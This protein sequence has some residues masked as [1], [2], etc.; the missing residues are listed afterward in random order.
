M[1][2]L[3]KFL[4]P[5]L[6]PVSFC[7]EILLLGLILLGLTRKQKAGKF[8]ITLGTAL[9][10][11]LGNV[12]ISDRILRPLESR[13]PPLG[14]TAGENP[15]RALPSVE[16]IVVLG[17]GESSDPTL[18]V[19]SQ[20]YPE[21]VV[22]LT[23]AIRLY[24][25][26]PGSKLVLSGGRWLDR[27][28]EAEIMARFVR[29]LGVSERDTILET[30]SRDTEEEAQI[31]QPIVGQKPFIL[32]TSA[33]HMPRS[34]ALFKKLGM[35]PIPAPTNF[36]SRPSGT[37]GPDDFFPRADGFYRSESALHECLGLVW[38]KLRGRI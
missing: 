28:T 10:T 11:L 1:F 30:K 8:L 13:Y 36:L 20:P 19:T 18:P 27:T 29:A 26:L 7:W 4:S 38:E 9:I 2:L 31:L 21:A 34:V 25:Q 35:N 14:V 37:L 6:A 5:L 32:V 15:E 22:R 3:K 17:G 12:P 33:A 16:L 24:R 23:E